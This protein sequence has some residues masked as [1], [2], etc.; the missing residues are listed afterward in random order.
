MTKIYIYIFSLLLLTTSCWPEDELI[1]PVDEY[2]PIEMKLNSITNSIY[3]HQTYFSLNQ[4]TELST[5]K[6]D[7]W[8]LAF[9]SSEKG[10]QI[11]MNSA[12]IIGIANLGNIDFSTNQI[13]SGTAFIYDAS[14]GNPDSIAIKNWID[15]SKNE[16]SENLY[17]VAEKIGLDYKPLKKIKFIEVTNSY[18]KFIYGNMEDTKADTFL[19]NK[20]MSTN[21]TKVSIREKVEV[22]NIEPIKEAWDFV[23][24]Q[25]QT[26]LFTDDGIAT[27][28]SVRGILINPNH[29]KVAK[30]FI[31]EEMASSNEAIKNIFLK[32]NKGIIDTIS[33]SANWDIIGWDWKNVEVD[34]SSNTASYKADPRKVFILNDAENNYYKLHFTSFYNTDGLKGFPTFEFALLN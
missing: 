7:D 34:Q 20:N 30:Y 15:T 2:K 16:Y 11:R 8:E 3:T 21:Y 9:E 17:V 1:E 14:S 29:V 23:F 10:C 33:F 18:Y 6:L 22:R 32:I 5:N 4:N 19:V 26:I 27:P 28:Y 13:P 12:Q 31:T 24:T 25:Y